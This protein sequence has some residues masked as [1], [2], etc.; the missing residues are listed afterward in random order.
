MSRAVDRTFDNYTRIWHGGKLILIC[1]PPPVRARGGIICMVFLTIRS[2]FG[3]KKMGTIW[4]SLSFGVNVKVK[5]E[6]G[7]TM[8]GDY[9]GWQIGYTLEDIRKGDKVFV[10]RSDAEQLYALL[11]I[12]FGD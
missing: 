6:S 3:G 10:K 7:P 8:V 12:Q 4:K 9:L 11:R 1:E 2:P 5:T